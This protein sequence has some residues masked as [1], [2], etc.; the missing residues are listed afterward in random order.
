LSRGTRLWFLTFF[1][2]IM[3]FFTLLLC[4][5]NAPFVTL[6]LP[7]ADGQGLNPLLQNP[8][9]IFHPPLLF[10]GYGG[11]VIPACLALAQAMNPGQEE[12]HWMEAA[13]SFTLTGWLFL[14][15]GIALGAWW[16]YMELGWGGYWAWD[17]VE[18]ASLIP[19]LIGT[20]ALHTGIVEQ[21][22]GKLHRTNIFLISLTTVSAFFATW[23]VRGNVVNSV[24]GYGEGNVGP[25]LLSFAVFFFAVICIISLQAKDTRSRPLEGLE[26]REGFVVMTA[27]LLIALCILILTATLWPVI[28]RL[29]TERP[30]GLDA[31]FYNSTCL[32]LFS[33]LLAL[34]A[35]CPWLK[36]QGGLRSW[37]RLL[38][39][40]A[41][42]FLAMG[43]LWNAGITRA[44]PLIAAAL[45]FS[46]VAGAALLLTEKGVRSW[47]PSAMACLVHASVG[48]IALGI[49][50]SGPYKQEVE[51]ELAPGRSV[52]V[53]P[54]SATLVQMYEGR[55]ENFSFIEAELRL[56]RGGTD[57][58]TVS[59]QR[60]LY[61]KFQRSAFSEAATHPSLG[62]EFYA[63]LL[64]MNGQNAVLRMSANPGVNWLWIGAALM[65]LAPFLGLR[66]RG[67]KK[68]AVTQA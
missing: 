46:V 65:S 24:H 68:Q 30:V 49:A 52:Q 51:T 45:G 11:F 13:R 64:G 55:G 62:S 47:M 41:V 2:C 36:W 28:S 12:Q 54:Y 10:L 19:W 33:V 1:L 56:S 3:A 48:I 44:L 16:A 18:N 20:A 21:R 42:F 9:M 15:A 66:R 50:F 17:P 8:G 25:L 34:L 61:D 27:W 43:L 67:A 60:R 58:G 37:K 32:P 4:T 59:A 63:T 7:P 39:V 38:A 26:T 57:A 40:F 29:W 35:V 53:G 23:L 14:S 31:R 22:R 5:R 6:P